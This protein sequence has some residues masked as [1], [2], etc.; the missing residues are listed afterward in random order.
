MSLERLLQSH[1]SGLS[2]SSIHALTK[3]DLTKRTLQRRL[4]TLAQEKRI[5]TEGDRKGRKYF[6]LSRP[7]SER[8]ADISAPETA[9]A[10][11]KDPVYFSERSIQIRDHVRK[12]LSLRAPVTFDRKFLDNYNP[13][14]GGLLTEPV[15]E[16]LWRLGRQNSDEQ[17]AGTF[18][19]Q[20]YDRLLIDLSW[21]SSRLEGNTYSLL[22]TEHL[23]VE[24]RENENKSAEET[25]MILNHKSA[26]ELLATPTEDIGFNSYTIRSLHAIL[27]DNLLSDPANGG[28][29][30]TSAVGIS[31][32]T[33]LPTAIPQ[34]IE[35]CLGDILK[36]ARAIPDPFEASFFIMVYL[37]YLQPFVDVNKRV[38]RLAANIPLIR[39]N[40][41]PLSF[42]DIDKEEYLQ[43]TLGVYE[44]HSIDYL[45][46][47][48]IWA[49]KRS[50]A[51]YSVIQES[52]GQP[53]SFRLKYRT[54]LKEVVR[55]AILAAAPPD[56][57]LQFIIAYVDKNIP[58]TDRRDFMETVEEEIAS[59]HEGNIAR[60]GLRPSEYSAWK[61]ASQ[62]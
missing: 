60:Y 47:V 1:P 30:R 48:F 46:D 22:D 52:I 17:P 45:R 37:P 20:I 33:Y 28:R 12:P 42:V 25:Q 13:E 15:R 43:A 49:Y 55:K 40:L 39:H 10:S 7:Q 54:V 21:N 59:L 26:I 6:P 32:S 38:S 44:L 18:L 34:L 19:R 29:L 27:S 50:C 8:I 23:L 16:Q 3:L 9:E 24:G 14:R 57:T 35:E 11:G 61:A 62:L 51:R 36:K 41:C 2:L 53:D 4:A 5:Q 31:Q 58:E 56:K